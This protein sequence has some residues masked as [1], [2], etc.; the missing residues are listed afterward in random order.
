MAK[1][2]LKTK[3]TVAS[4]PAF[5]KTLPDVQVQK[6]CRLL[7]KMMKDAV[8][9]PA[10]MWGPAIIGFGDVQLKYA[11]GR[12][13]DWFAMGF[14]PRKGTLSLYLQCGQD[15][16]MKKHLKALG[17]HKLSGSC[18]HIKKLA[19]VDLKV[20]DAMVRHAAGSPICGCGQ[21]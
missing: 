13:L 4:V 21:C 15:A 17:K 10:K 9:A 11:S 2:E 19:D 16:T 20:L 14:S 6:D 3:K 12:E 8:G 5:L 7:I 18:L 1:A